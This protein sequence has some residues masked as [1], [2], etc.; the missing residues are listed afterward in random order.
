MRER[1]RN[2]EGGLRM[3]GG[4]RISARTGHTHSTSA[5]V[6]TSECAHVFT[7]VHI[8]TANVTH[9]RCRV[10]NKDKSREDK[11][12]KYTQK[13]A[14]SGKITR[15]KRAFCRVAGATRGRE[16]KGGGEGAGGREDMKY[17]GGGR[18]KDNGGRRRGVKP[19]GKRRNAKIGALA[20]NRWR[21]RRLS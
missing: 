8:Y 1:E 2:S 4:V 10:R 9:S 19:A 12:I 15:A 5:Y 18:G 17:R 21:G 6:Y 14:G 7:H 3:R 11:K 13:G 20:H 16:G